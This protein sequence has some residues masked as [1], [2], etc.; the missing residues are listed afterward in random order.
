MK[1]YLIIACLALLGVIAA[2]DDL[3]PALRND[4][5][6]KGLSG[7]YHWYL[8]ASYVLLAIAIVG[9]SSGTAMHILTVIAGLALGATAFTNTFA[10]LVDKWS[11]GKHSLWHTRS[12]IVVFVAAFLVELSGDQNTIRIA[13]TVFTIL[14]PTIAYLWFRYRPT[15]IKGVMVAASPAAEKL[16][17]AGLCLWFISWAL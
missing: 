14:A 15:I 3:I 5:I 1:F 9:A 2:Q 16:Y 13:L 8:D 12:T 4:T 7:P 6:S 17:V 10:T 11:G